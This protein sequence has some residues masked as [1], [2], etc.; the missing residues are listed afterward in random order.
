M[1]KKKSSEVRLLAPRRA[2]LT[3]AQEREAVA[4]LVE[5]LL[6]AAAKRRGLRS[7]GALDSASGGA[8][9]SVVPFPG[10]RGRPREAA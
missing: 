4:L 2:R 7:A 1:S 5:L 3:F 6:D 9:A 10:D 8:F